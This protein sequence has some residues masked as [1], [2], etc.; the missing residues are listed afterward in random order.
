MIP[1][2]SKEAINASQTPSPR[3]LPRHARPYHTCTS[4]SSYG[5]SRPR[6]HPGVPGWTSTTAEQRGLY[7]RKNQTTRHNRRGQQAHENDTHRVGVVTAYKNEREHSNPSSRGPAGGWKGDKIVAQG[8]CS[9]PGIGIQLHCTNDSCI[10]WPGPIRIYTTP[11][12]QY[13]HVLT[14]AG[15]SNS[16]KVDPDG[17]RRLDPGRDVLPN[18]VRSA[19]FPSPTAVFSHEKHQRV[20]RYKRTYS[21]FDIDLRPSG[22]DQPHTCAIHL[23]IGTSVFIILTIQRCSNISFGVGRVSES[24]VRL[25]RNFRR[26]PTR[27]GSPNKEGRVRKLTLL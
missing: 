13:F 4:P 7:T 19:P 8:S 10:Q 18:K 11:S 24:W 15:D 2:G 6:D 9:D 14:G 3:I 17:S 16:G 5:L 27:D 1:I 12:R 25:K 26:Q 23:A 20:V 22:K 21:S